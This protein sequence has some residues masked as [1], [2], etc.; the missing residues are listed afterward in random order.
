M[1]ARNALHFLGD[2]ERNVDTLGIVQIALEKYRRHRKTV[3]DAI[4]NWGYDAISSHDPPMAR[5]AEF[6]TLKLYLVPTI[7]SPETFIL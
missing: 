7:A 5:V 1:S 2:A 3:D 4:T 6:Q